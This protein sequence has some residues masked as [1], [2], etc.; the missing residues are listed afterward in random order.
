MV[1][2]TLSMI[3]WQSKL[4]IFPDYNKSCFQLALD[5]LQTSPFRYIDF[6][7]TLPDWL[8]KNL[9]LH[10]ENQEVETRISLLSLLGPDPLAPEQDDTQAAFMIRGHSSR[11]ITRISQPGLYIQGSTTGFLGP[12][13]ETVDAQEG[14]I[15]IRLVCFHRDFNWMMVGRERSDGNFA[16]IGHTA[17]EDGPGYFSARQDD[18][19]CYIDREDLLM[20]TIL[21]ESLDQLSRGASKMVKGREALSLLLSRRVCRFEGSSYVMRDDLEDWA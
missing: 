3:D 9:Q 6:R 19:W 12:A 14:D 11:L 21:N 1:Y 16:L 7:N 18:I 4:R 5:I 2:A 13:L 17:F 20:L 15:G 10:G 8:V